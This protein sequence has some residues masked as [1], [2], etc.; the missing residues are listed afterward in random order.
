MKLLFKLENTEYYFYF[1]PLPES[2]V[3]WH[4]RNV[5]GLLEHPSGSELAFLSTTDEHLFRLFPAR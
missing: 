4:D 2:S 3:E 1:S 5:A